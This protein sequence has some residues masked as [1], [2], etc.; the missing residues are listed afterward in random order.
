MDKILVL[1]F[2]DKLPK[3]KH[4]TRI[5]KF[6]NILNN[7]LALDTMLQQIQLINNLLGRILLPILQHLHNALQDGPKYNFG[8]SG[9]LRSNLLSM[10]IEQLGKETNCLFRR[11]QQFEKVFSQGRD[12]VGRRVD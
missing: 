2:V 10:F 12:W 3:R 1:I 8:V 6:V 7:I 11:G 4:N 5:E 9:Q